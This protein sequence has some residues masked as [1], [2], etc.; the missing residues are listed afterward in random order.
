[1]VRMLIEQLIDLRILRKVRIENLKFRTDLQY[2]VMDVWPVTQYM[3]VY[4][5]RLLKN[6]KIKN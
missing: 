4:K 3:V 2:Q 5:G 6:L 1:M